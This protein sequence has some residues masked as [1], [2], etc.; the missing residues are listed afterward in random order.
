M[1]FQI[2]LDNS[3]IGI[4]S[5]RDLHCSNRVQLV[6]VGFNHVDWVGVFDTQSVGTNSVE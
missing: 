6:R 3:R 1:G 5:D 2:L 4:G